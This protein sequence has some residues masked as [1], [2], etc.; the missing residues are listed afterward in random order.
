MA[1]D[2]QKPTED[3]DFLL[4]LI[5]SEVPDAPFHEGEKEGKREVEKGLLC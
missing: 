4:D 2:W 1:E 5:V 3:I